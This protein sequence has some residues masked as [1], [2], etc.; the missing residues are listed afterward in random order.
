MNLKPIL[1]V[2]AA[3]SLSAIAFAEEPIITFTTDLYSVQGSSNSFTFHIGGKGD[4]IDVDCGFGTVE[5]DLHEAVFDSETQSIQATTVTGTVNQN[6][7][8]KVYGDASA[9][10]YL[11]VEGCY[12]TSISMPG[13][14]NLEILNMQH[15]LLTGLDL[16]GFNKLQAL[17]L[18]DNPFSAETPLKIGGNKPDLALL[19]IGMSNYLDSSFNLSD[20]PAMVSFEAF[21]AKGLTNCDPTGCP[22]LVQLSID[23]TPVSSIDVSKNSKLAIL[24][25]ADTKISSIDIS[26]NPELQQFYC[27]HAAAEY[28]DYKISSLDLSNNPKLFYLFAGYNSISEL[29]LSNNPKLFELH[30]AYNDLHSLDL[31]NNKN[32]YNVDLSKNYFGF[33]TLPANPGDWGEYFYEQ[34][35]MPIDRSYKVGDVLDFS[36]TMLR[37]DTETIATLYQ[38]NEEDYSSPIL[39]D[40]SAYTFENGK[41][42]LNTVLPDSVYVSFDNSELSL[43]ALTTSNFVVKS[44]A[45]FGKD[46]ESINFMPA[47]S[48]I[49]FRVGIA[50][51]TPETPKRFKVDFDGTVKEFTCTGSGIY[52]GNLVTGSGNLIKILLPEGTDISAFSVEGQQIY[53]LNFPNARS[54]S[55]LKL[56]GTGLYDI[57]LKYLSLLSYL[58]LRDNHLST[59]D[60]AGY[61]RYFTKNRLST[62]IIPGNGISDINIEGFEPLFTIDASGNSLK[63]FNF[64]TAIRATDINI[65][66]NLL[67]SANLAKCENIVSANI[68]D[69]HISEFT[70]P[71]D[72]TLANLDISSNNM[73]F[74]NLPRPDQIGSVY[75]Y[76]GQADLPIAE[77]GPGID[78]SAQYIDIDGNITMYTLYKT[79][80]TVITGNDSYTESGGKIKFVDTEL[81]NVYCVITNDAFPNLSLRTTAIKVAPM[82][83]DVIASFTTPVGGETATLSLASEKISSIYIDWKGDGVELTNY[84][85]GTSYTLFNAVTSAGA[86]VKVYGYEESAPMTVFSISGVT[87]ENLDISR[88]TSVYALTLDNSGLSEITLPEGGNIRE[89][90][91]SGNNLS[92]IDLSGHPYI[93][94]LS[95]NNNNLSGYFDIS[96]LKNLQLVSLANNG[97]TSVKIDNANLWYLDLCGNRLNSIDLSAAPNLEQLALSH[98]EFSEIDITNLKS[99]HGLLLD[100][101]K[102]TFATLPEVRSQ[103]AI[104]T[105]ANQAP[106][107]AIANGLNVDLSSQA[108]VGDTETVYSWFLDMPVQDKEG[109]WIGEQLEA[110]DEYFVENGI[111]TFERPLRHLVCL[112]RNEQFPKLAL[113]STMVDITSGIENASVE[114]PPVELYTLTG[115]R[116]YSENPAPGIYIRRQG[117][118]V[119]KISIR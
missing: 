5:Y 94:S 80:G 67:T 107:E 19:Q 75:T 111:T 115:H 113:F 61:N 58:E 99:L 112:M 76:G 4:Y 30:I 33:A 20:Y 116:V 70:L 14:T 26:N 101:N 87:M 68:S 54:L 98:N 114:V 41:L 10:D 21:G 12:I 97:L 108:K 23:V 91:L 39:V 95:L 36:S 53:S 106:I 46:I 59:L 88:L 96:S 103:Y 79:D 42:T 9:I 48:N 89:L 100:S 81:G 83:T 62:L 85:L 110:N 37:E 84:A 72:I 28:S 3:M 73:T 13:L 11:S 63:E 49:S 78:L 32:L 15:N 74:A 6:G 69:N 65:S 44:T 45:E 117:R 16:T 77:T 71:N 47:N 92:D 22:E 102:F 38:V 27:G 118:N 82:P 104:Y 90:I 35:P 119:T 18:S 25:I 24:N 56:T 2:F 34:R 55:E 8:V 50:G 60:L 105:Y 31:S 40:P 57:D 51:A 17:Y 66:H 43:Y 86:N 109:N 1:S 7:V 64:E 93:T 52:S 29:D